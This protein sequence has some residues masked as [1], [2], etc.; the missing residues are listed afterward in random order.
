MDVKAESISDVMA[1]V[2]EW[3]QQ[4]EATLAS[5]STAS[6]PAAPPINSEDNG[7][8]GAE[9]YGASKFCI[10]CGIKIPKVAKFCPDCGVK[11]ETVAAL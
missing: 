6:V 3:N 4:F 10:D 2:D 1:I 9:G 8:I 7:G 5:K 11:Q